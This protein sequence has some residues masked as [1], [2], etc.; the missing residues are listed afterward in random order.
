MKKEINML[1]DFRMH[2]DYFSP[3]KPRIRVFLDRIEFLNPGCLPKDIESIMKEDFTMPRN[4][5]RVH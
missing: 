3:M 5:G 4:S 1:T 2:S